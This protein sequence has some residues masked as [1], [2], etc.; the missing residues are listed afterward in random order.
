MVRA[1]SGPITSRV[2]VSPAWPSLAITAPLRAM[3]ASTSRAVRCWVSATTWSVS[4]AI[5][6]T[7]LSVAAKPCSTCSGSQG[8]ASSF[9]PMQ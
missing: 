4:A 9:S 1:C 3:V 5:A 7:V 8:L 2:S 6:A